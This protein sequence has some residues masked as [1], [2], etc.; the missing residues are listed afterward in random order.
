M[1]ASGM[2]QGG[3]TALMLAASAGMVGTVNALLHKGANMEARD[4]IRSRMEMVSV[5]AS[6]NTIFVVLA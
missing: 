4:P 2:M 1:Q 6:V 3:W 5:V